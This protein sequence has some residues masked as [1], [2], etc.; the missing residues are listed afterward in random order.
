MYNA[1]ARLRT[2]HTFFRYPAGTFSHTSQDKVHNNITLNTYSGDFELLA[3]K[4]SYFH[5]FSP[6]NTHAGFEEIF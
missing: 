3:F 6:E 4:I 1:T 2:G 5:I